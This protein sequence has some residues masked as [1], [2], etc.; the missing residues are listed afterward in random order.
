MAGVTTLIWGTTMIS[1]KVLLQEGLSPAQ[2]LFC[3]FLLGYVFLWILYPRTHRIRSI[4][5]ELLFVGM[6]VFGGSLYFLTENTALVYTQATNVSLICALVPLIT[7][8]LS[9]FVLKEKLP[10]RFWAGSLIACIGVSFV[11]LNGNFILKLGPL[12]DLLAFSAICSW[13][14]YC[15]LVKKLHYKYNS[16]FVTRNLFFYGLLTLAPYFLYEPFDVS[17][18]L[19]QRFP[20]WGNLLFLGLIASSLCYVMWNSAMHEL[21]VI[22]TNTYLYFMPLVTIVT[23]VIFI[24]EQITVY[25]LLGAAF[26]LFGLWI[27]NHNKKSQVIK[28]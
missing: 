3:R 25:I 28:A 21:G 5:D 27:A 13:A 12:G 20:V 19:F 24:S 1:S 6:G 2:I 11:I 15:M 22:K 18:E 17:L 26:I 16:L 4:H 7:A 23:A 9:F 14:I 8:I 10:G